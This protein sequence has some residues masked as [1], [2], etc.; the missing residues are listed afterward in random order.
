VYAGVSHIVALASTVRC[1]IAGSTAAYMG[2]ATPI[3]WAT[4]DKIEIDFDFQVD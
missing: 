1:A 4:G 3:T 2:S